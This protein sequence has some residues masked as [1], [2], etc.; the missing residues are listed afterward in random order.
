MPRSK[1]NRLLEMC[2]YSV[3]TVQST[4]LCI[5]VSFSS[6][7][8]AIST[9][10]DKSLLQSF[11]DSCLTS[12]NGL[13]P[14]REF[15]LFVPVTLAAGISWGRFKKRRAQLNLSQ[16]G[17]SSE[18]NSGCVNFFWHKFLS[19][20]SGKSKYYN[21]A[22]RRQPKRSLRAIKLL[23]TVRTTWIFTVCLLSCVNER[24]MISNI[25]SLLD[26]RQYSF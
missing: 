1:N 21:C 19:S 12:L 17:R 23:R 22:K 16:K 3:Y 18:L 14:I 13:P 15:G 24:S 4:V 6:S 10:S 8:S 5:P 11:K 2:M 9:R 7:Q 25:N 20:F 26:S